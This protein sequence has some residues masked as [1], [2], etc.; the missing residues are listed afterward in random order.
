MEQDMKYVYEVYKHGSFS[1][2]AE[3]LFITLPALSISIQRVEKAIGMPLFDRS[4]KP[5]RLTE[6]GNLYIEKFHQIQ[7]MERELAQQLNDLSELNTG[8][9]RIG[10]SHYF[11]SYVL[12]EILTEYRHAHPGIQLT[13]L[14]AGSNELL[15]L[16]ADHEIDITFNCMEKPKDSFCRIPGF[17]DTILISVPKNMAVNE[18]LSEYALSAADI[19]AQKHQEFS[20]PAVPLTPFAD[21]PFILLSPGNNLYQRSSTFFAD[22]KIT[23]N[24]CLQVSQLVTAYHLSRSGMAATFISD[25]LVSAFHDSVWFYKIASQSSIRVFDLV[26][27]DGAYMSNAMKEFVRIFQEHY[28]L[29]L[30]Q[31]KKK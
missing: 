1:K 28:G 21:T 16:L 14:E 9:L 24:V 18:Q 11:N 4:K 20:T 29:H 17:I 25:L 2:A 10:G 12:P 8:S 5:L 23:P 13:L 30:D 3:A 26:M 15:H 19:I 22:A 6:A 31:R 27:S 7:Y